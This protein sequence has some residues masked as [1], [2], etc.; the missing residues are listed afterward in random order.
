MGSDP[1]LRNTR[2]LRPTD[3]TTHS[4]S[5]QLLEKK[6]TTANSPQPVAQPQKPSPLS[7]P[8]VAERPSL[9]L[10]KAYRVIDARSPSP[11]LAL[12]DH[13]F[14][15]TNNLIHHPEDKKKIHDYTVHDRVSVSPLSFSSSSSSSSFSSLSSLEEH[16]TS[17]LE[18]TPPASPV[19]IREPS[20]EKEWMLMER[21][22][23]FPRMKKE[24]EQSPVFIKP[25]TPPIPAV[26]SKKNVQMM[27]E[28]KFPVPKEKKLRQ[29]R[30]DPMIVLIEACIRGDQNEM[31][32]ILKECQNDPNLKS[33]VNEINN[34]SLLHI[35]LMHGNQHLVEFLV[36]EVQVDIN[37]GDND[38]N[39]FFFLENH[40]LYLFICIF[41]LLILSFFFSLAFRHLGWTCLHYAAA[42]KLWG[43]LEFL[44]SLPHCNLNAR[45]NDGWEVKDCSKTDRDRKRCTCKLS[46]SFSKKKKKKKKTK[47]NESI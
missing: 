24:D 1:F 41:I 46:I 5:I 21:P 37:H 16:H 33:S 4:E 25:A 42:L 36:N 9:L 3:C 10:K 40:K 30:F 28:M 23:C 8:A 6:M 19:H 45:T 7:T 29:V 27:D 31:I 20:I 14:N 32:D 47:Q 35:A 13:Y 34:K 11:V 38:G 18:W 12:P 26:I 22:G 43:S 39:F 15:G 44:T 17:A 2:K